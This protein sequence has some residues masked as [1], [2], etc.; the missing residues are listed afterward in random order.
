[1]GPRGTPYDQLSH[2]S[3]QMDPPPLPEDV[4]MEDEPQ[5]Y[6]PS[7]STTQ[8]DPNEA[9]YEPVPVVFDTSLDPRARAAGPGPVTV[10]GR[11]IVTSTAQT[12]TSAESRRVNRYIKKYKK[13]HGKNAYPPKGHIESLLEDYRRTTLTDEP[14]EKVSEA[15]TPLITQPRRRF[16]GYVRAPS[17]PIR[18]MRR[19]PPTVVPVFRPRPAVGRAAVPVAPPRRVGPAPRRLPARVRAPLP[20]ARPVR[21]PRV[22]YAPRRVAVVRNAIGYRIPPVHART[23]VAAAQTSPSLRFYGSAGIPVPRLSWKHLAPGHYI[24]R[25][26]RGLTPGIKQHVHHLLKR[27][28]QYIWINGVRHTRRQAATVIFDLLGKHHAVDIKL[29]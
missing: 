5:P 21:A 29:A 16:P 9:Q 7:G 28:G 6:D 26:R 17:R 25:A 19:P 18:P 20:V 3:W 11:R 27:A 12:L 24:A 13:Q 22:A 2:L 23:R 4:E 14:D 15:P 8:Y 10:A 1:M